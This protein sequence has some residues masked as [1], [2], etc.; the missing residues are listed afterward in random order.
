MDRNSLRLLPASLGRLKRL[1]VFT[2][3]YNLLEAVPAHLLA[4]RALT[5]LVS[6]I[7]MLG[8]IFCFNF[9]LCKI[10]EFNT[11]MRQQKKKKV[12]KKRRHVLVS[13]NFKSEEMIL[14]KCRDEF[15]L[16]FTFHL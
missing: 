15:A 5:L 3:G 9:N 6:S 16:D 7:P 12:K 13:K 4:M 10:K 2:A 14:E 11:P 1:R 8:E